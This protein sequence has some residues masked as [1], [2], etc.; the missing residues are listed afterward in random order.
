MCPHSV[1]SVIRCHPQTRGLPHN[2]DKSAWCYCPARILQTASSARSESSDAS[3]ASGGSPPPDWPRRNTPT[4]SSRSAIAFGPAPML[5]PPTESSSLVVRRTP[6]RA[7]DW[8]AAS[9]ARTTIGKAARS[10]GPSR[11]DLA[12]SGP[13]PSLRVAPAGGRASRQPNSGT[14]RTSASRR[15]VM[16][17]PPCLPRTEGDR[18]L[19]IARRRASRLRLLTVSPDVTPS[20]PFMATG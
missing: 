17:A 19:G 16:E 10:S 8:R 12:G 2:A 7:A 20:S 13:I 9:L 18:T 5:S 3:S 11:C 6:R 14:L 15:S 1:K 4:R